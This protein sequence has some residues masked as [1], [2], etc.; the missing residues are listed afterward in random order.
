MRCRPWNREFTYDVPEEEEEPG[1]KEDNGK[2]DPSAIFLSNWGSSALWKN[3]I[4]FDVND[5]M[6]AAINSIKNKKYWFSGK[7]SKNLTL[8]D[9]RKK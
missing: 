6:L 2:S 8:I 5:N 9:T 4:S 3:L 1:E 7:W